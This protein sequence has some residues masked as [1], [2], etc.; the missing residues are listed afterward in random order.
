M[1]I[2]EIKKDV[3]VKTLILEKGDRINILEQNV[4]QLLELKKAIMTALLLIDKNKDKAKELI[5][6][7]IDNLDNYEV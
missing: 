1:K 3:E 2:I 7:V 4:N 5:K 6:Y